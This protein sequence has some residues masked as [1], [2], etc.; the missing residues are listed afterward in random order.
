MLNANLSFDGSTGQILNYIGNKKAIEAPDIVRIGPGRY[1][2]T[3][4]SGRQIDAARI[5]SSIVTVQC[6]SPVG[7]GTITNVIASPKAVYNPTSIQYPWSISFQ[8]ETQNI[9]P[10]L[11]L[12]G[13][14]L[15]Y[16]DRSVVMVAFR[17]KNRMQRYPGM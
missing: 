15:S 6:Q 11:L 8:I 12:L 7:S 2:V 4:L 10:A 1:T 9:V 14:I 3:F 16:V 5:G 17:A 13:P